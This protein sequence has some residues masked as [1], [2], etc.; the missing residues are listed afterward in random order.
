[1]G[2]S[3]NGV[4]GL[5]MFD[6]F[7]TLGN[8]VDGLLMLDG[9]STLDDVMLG[10]FVREVVAGMI[11]SCVSV[12]C[13]TDVSV[14]RSCSAQMYAVIMRWVGWVSLGSSVRVVR[15]MDCVNRGLR[16]NILWRMDC[17]DVRI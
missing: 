7:S 9:F 11:S 8:G 3:A 15:M 17:A 1:V 10:M 5:L 2:V 4:D 13:S 6:G 12:G 14:D 16:V